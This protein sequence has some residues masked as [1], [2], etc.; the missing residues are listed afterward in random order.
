M[1]AVQSNGHANSGINGSVQE[2]GHTHHQSNTDEHSHSF[3]APSGGEACADDSAGEVRTVA[4][5][6]I[7]GDALHN[8]VDGLSMG[9][10]FSRRTFFGV[11]VSLAILCEE[12]PHELGKDNSGGQGRMSPNL[13]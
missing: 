8:F 13:W 12:L 11:S 1:K 10:A 5:M 4:W 3:K 9:A 7:F 6:V 2:N